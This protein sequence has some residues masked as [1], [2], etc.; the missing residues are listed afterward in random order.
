MLSRIFWVGIAG[1]A[2]VTGMVI[3]DGDWFWDMARESEVSTKTER[4]IEARIEQAIDRSIDKME[5]VTVDGRDVRV[6]RAQKDAM[7]DA[8]GRLVKAEG[9][10]VALKI[11]DAADAEI[12]AA[13]V[14]RDEAKTRVEQMEAQMAA[15][16]EA[17]RSER[18]AIREQVRAEVRDSVRDAVKN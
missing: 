17:Q 16:G 15:Q 10:L 1:V 8:I 6:S 4:G 14:E 13:S 2:L 11:R 5:V 3:Q 18:D 9:H 12:E 7:A